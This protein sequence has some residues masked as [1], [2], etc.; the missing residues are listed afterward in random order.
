MCSSD[1]E[2]QRIAEIE[3]ASAQYQEV[4]VAMQQPG[5]DAVRKQILVDNPIALYGF[6]PV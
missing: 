5:S 4:L 3:A 6:D 2:G 1:L